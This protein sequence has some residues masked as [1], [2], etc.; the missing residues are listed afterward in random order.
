MQL[1]GPDFWGNKAREIRTLLY[2]RWQDCHRLSI[3]GLPSWTEIE[4]C[5]DLKALSDLEKRL[6]AA[7]GRE[8][9][10]RKRKEAA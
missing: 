1:D 6:E 7:T 10:P 8:K 2:Q 3:E 9:K 5:P 4:S